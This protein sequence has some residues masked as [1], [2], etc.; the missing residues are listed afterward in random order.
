MMRC[1]LHSDRLVWSGNAAIHIETCVYEFTDAMLLFPVRHSCKK[2][3]SHLRKS[4]ECQLT[5]AIS[6]RLRLVIYK[7]VM[8]VQGV[9]DTVATK[10]NLVS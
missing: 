6:S 8:W 5:M 3:A 4:R 1:S 2:M 7:I 10:A 9:R